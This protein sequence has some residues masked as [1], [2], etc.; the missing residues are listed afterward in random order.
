MALAE[1]K[2]GDDAI[3]GG[4]GQ[5]QSLFFLPSTTNIT[6]L[7]AVLKFGNEAPFSNYDINVPGVADNEELKI[8]EGWH[9]MQ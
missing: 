8:G 2:S 7:T 6:G 3:L 1:V 4:N 5:I 9:N